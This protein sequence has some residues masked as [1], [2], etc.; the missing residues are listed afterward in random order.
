MRLLT[1]VPILFQ[2]RSRIWEVTTK[3]LFLDLETIVDLQYSCVIYSSDR[4]LVKLD[5]DGAGEE[6]VDMGGMTVGDFVHLSFA[7]EEETMLKKERMNRPSPTLQTLMELKDQSLTVKE[8]TCA[9]AIEIRDSL[10]NSPRNNFWKILSGKFVSCISY[11]NFA[12]KVG[13]VELLMEELSRLADR[14][15]N[16]SGIHGKIKTILHARFNLCHPDQRRHGNF[17]ILVHEVSVY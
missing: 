4:A 3:L 1:T 13:D 2:S 8:L 11:E 15:E 12:K 9:L 7:P 6:F 17:Q 10:L 16:A 14:A 5:L